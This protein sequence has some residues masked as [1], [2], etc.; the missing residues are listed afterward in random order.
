M[1][2]RR[3]EDTLLALL[4]SARVPILSQVVKRRLRLRHMVSHSNLK[5]LPSTEDM[6]SN[7]SPLATRDLSIFNHR[8]KLDTPR[9]SLSNNSSSSLPMATKPLHRVILLLRL[10]VLQELVALRRAW[11][12]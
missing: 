6:S 1:A 3:R 8:N 5:P 11:V 12:V 9:S 7:N 10:V 4:T 2:R